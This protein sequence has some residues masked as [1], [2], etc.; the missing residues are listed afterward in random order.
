MLLA[1]A[2][3]GIAIVIAGAALGLRKAP[4]LAD[5]AFTLAL[6]ITPY[7]FAYGTKSNIFHIAPAAFVVV[8]LATAYGLHKTLDPARARG[9]SAILGAAGLVVTTLVVAVAMERPYRLPVPLRLQ[10]TVLAVGQGQSHLRVDAAMAHYVEAF[11]RAIGA[12]ADVAPGVIDLTGASPGALFAAGAFPVGLPWMIGRL[13]GSE[14]VAAEALRKVDCPTLAA[15][16]I[17][18]EEGGK[19]ALPSSVLEGIGRQLRPG[20][21]LRGPN[22]VQALTP[23][24]EDLTAATAR[25][26]AMRS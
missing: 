26:Q 16:W 11:R 22:G 3:A 25:C 9:A 2:P 8:T 10:E 21:E 5:V 1:A 13:P 7:T 18:S 23:P 17:L 20:I 19:R 14:T 15:S 12:R 24:E 4:R 6:L